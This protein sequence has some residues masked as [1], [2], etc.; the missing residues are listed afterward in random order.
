MGN[1]H[2]ATIPPIVDI[3]HV[4]RLRL[5]W[6]KVA[7]RGAGPGID[8]VTVATYAQGLEE[9]LDLLARRLARGDWRASPGRRIE[10]AED[11]DRPVVISTVED[12]IVQR[13]LVDALT[14]AYEAL[15]N[16]AAR[17]YRPGLSLQGTLAR[18][19]R[20]LTEGRRWFVRTDITRFFESIDRERLLAQMATDGVDAVTVR[21]VRELLRA[22]LVEGLAWHDPEGGIPQGSA[23][24]PLLSNVYLRG[25]DEAMLAAGHAYVRYAD[26]IVVL[27]AD[28][29]GAGDAALLL[30][31]LV[32]QQG[33]R[34]N[35]RKTQ[36]G[37]LRDG[38]TYLGMRFDATGRRVASGVLSALTA[39]ASA[40]AGG[41]QPYHPLADLIDEAA[42][43]YGPRVVEWVETL[44]LIAAVAFQQTRLRNT[45][46]LPRL[47]SRR[48]DRPRDEQLAGELHVMLTEAWAQ[49]DDPTCDLAR[50]ID[51]RAAMRHALSDEARERLAAALR[52]PVRLLGALQATPD[53][54]VETVARSG[55][56]RL[57][58]AARALAD[59]ATAPTAPAGSASSGEPAGAGAPIVPDATAL[60][61]FAARFRGRDDV[62]VAEQ[63]A[64][65]GHWATRTISGRLTADAIAEHLAGARRFGLHVVEAG[66]H[67]RLATLETRV[68]RDV[69]VPAAGHAG[70]ASTT[71]ETL[72]AWQNRVHDDAVA[73]STAARKHGLNTVIEAPGRFHRRL[74]FFF[75]GPIALR[76][77]HALLRLVDEWAGPAVEGLVRAPTPPADRLNHAPGPLVLL[78]LGRHPRSREWSRLVRH[79]GEPCERPL[80]TLL[81]AA[82]VETKRVI[83]IVCRA[84]APPDAPKP[85]EMPAHAPRTLRMLE[86]CNVLRALARKGQ[87]LGALEPMERATIVET[88][89]HLPPAEVLPAMRTFLAAPDQTDDALR[90][91]LEKRPAC[92]ISCGR[93]RQRHAALSIEVGCECAFVGLGNGVYPTPLLHGLAPREIA[94]FRPAGKAPPRD[95]AAPPAPAPPPIAG[96]TTALSAA[97]ELWRRRLRHLEDAQR[98]ADDAAR[99]LADALDA[100]GIE[101]LRATDGAIERIA[102]PP[103]VRLIRGGNPPK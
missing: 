75:D 15:L 101:R 29:A 61:R 62:H 76:H 3:A 33:L 67:V 13:A 86:G 58:A 18:V 68:R 40:L 85:A 50:L 14:P 83:E 28:E 47:A 44:P 87:R 56:S 12:R 16:E 84:P 36:R 24:S 52:L 82:V 95:A 31:T 9:R 38:F 91:R 70:E 94:A 35:R 60:A 98:T 90:R 21:R 43:W 17:A 69:V 41:L 46:L 97:V 63:L 49:V 48:R 27:A 92:P 88:V 37:H 53:R 10:L 22:G 5:A 42:Y 2:T 4:E 25:L 81:G 72:R 71:A 78:P 99:Q 23:L 93:I 39:R 32:E 59:L 77:A 102:E 100:Q 80:D 74:W 54:L 103:Y 26:D 66:E 6:D 19:D 55:A 11:P 20:W 96:P 57:A 1:E 30:D 64:P 34:L 7:R 89:S 51:A 73:L 45:T 8:R 79:D 65:D